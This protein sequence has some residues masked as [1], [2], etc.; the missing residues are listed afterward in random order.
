MSGVGFV[1]YHGGM[2]R[3]LRKLVREAGSGKRERGEKLGGDDSD[4][5]TEMRRWRDGFVPQ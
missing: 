4:A 3:G 1:F 2:F 5:W